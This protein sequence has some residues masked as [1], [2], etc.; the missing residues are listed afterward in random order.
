MTINERPDSS[1]EIRQFMGLV[2]QQ[3]PSDVQP[4][5]AQV[6]INVGVTRPD[7]LDVRKGYR[8]VRFEE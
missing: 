8:V 3:D 4:G 7:Q 5:A 6:Q 2:T 1:V